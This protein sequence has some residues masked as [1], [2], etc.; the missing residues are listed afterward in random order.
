M[1]IGFKK[2]ILLSFIILQG[3]TLKVF[4]QS[5]LEEL[6]KISLA[7]YPG[8][9][10]KKMISQAVAKDVSFEKAGLM[11]S[12]VASYQINYATYNNIP[13][14]YLPQY[15][16]PISGPTSAENNYSAAYGS[17]AGLLFNWEPVTFGKRESK[18]GYAQSLEKTALA[19]EENAIFEHKVRFIEAYLDYWHAHELVKIHENNLNR[20]GYNLDVSRALVL[21]GL[22]PG[23]DSAQIKAEYA[24]TH[25]ELLNARKQEMSRLARLHELLGTDSIEIL[26]DDSFEQFEWASPAIEVQEHPLQ[27][28]AKEQRLSELAQKKVYARSLLP[29]LRIW[30]TGY[31]RGS[32]IDTHD[33]LNGSGTNTPNGLGFSRYNYGVGF[34]ISLPLLQFASVNQKQQKQG[35]LVA[36]REAYQQEIDQRLK[37]QR[38]V[39]AI[40]LDNAMESLELSPVFLEASQYTYEALQSRYDAG[41]VNLSELMQAQYNL[42]KSE[43][44]LKATYAEAW[45]ALLYNVALQGDINIFLKQL[46]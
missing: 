35:L 33:P 20:F 29:D 3:F 26:I 2:I 32:G 10:A 42:A 30:G 34:Q 13:G 22:R 25:I 8:L 36:A 23:V 1:I 21:N 19:D 16:M 7:N 46:Q 14:M 12:L 41:L 9:Q 15:L 43:T 44:D 6:L 17:A 24:K 38:Q 18:I 11:P 4:S 5:H 39:A 28:L 27:K 31:A 45:K 40:A 37:K